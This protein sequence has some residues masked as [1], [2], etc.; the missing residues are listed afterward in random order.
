MHLSESTTLPTQSSLPTPSAPAQSLSD[1]SFELECLLAQLQEEL[2]H[3]E[4]H[5]EEMQHM[6]LTSSSSDF[7]SSILREIDD[8][9]LKMQVKADQISKVAKLQKQM[10]ILRRM[11]EGKSHS[12]SGVGNTWDSAQA[13][14]KSATIPLCED[15]RRVQVLTT[16][17][18]CGRA[19][20]CSHC[21]ENL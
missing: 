4:R 13:S 19:T 15:D 12:S 20:T 5:R 16:I 10:E 6:M 9:K 1:S 3:F 21:Q 14:S 18:A 2:S 11:K 17:T 7:Q 8:I